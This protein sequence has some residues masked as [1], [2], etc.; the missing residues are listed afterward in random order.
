M[1]IALRGAVSGMSLVLMVSIWTSRIMRDAQFAFTFLIAAIFLRTWSTLPESIW[2][3]D[4]VLQAFQ[5]FGSIGAFAVTWFLLVIFLDHRRFIWLWLAS[6]ALISIWIVL[7][8]LYPQTVPVLRAYASAHFLGLLVVILYS[9]LDDLQDARRRIRP[10]MSSFLLVYCI[11]LSLTSQPMQD[12]RP[13][14]DALFQSSAL[15]FFMG[16]FAIW[17]LK[18]N[19]SNWPGATTSRPASTP[20]AQDSLS[21]QTILI[22]RIQKAMDE[23]IWQTEGL[24]VGGL[25]QHVKAPEHQVRKAINQVLGH[26]NF[27]NFINRARID[28][29]KARLSDLEMTENTILEIAYYVGFSSLGP[30]NRAFRENTGLSP[31]DFRKQILQE[32]SI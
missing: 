3:P 4:R 29:A 19:L 24:T 30:F 5:M 17:A 15:F 26:R 20:G 14:R 13:I 18:A 16:L 27:A 1:D 6:G 2:M 12:T 10:A 9:G 22:R 8:Q 28:A 11:G 32:A 23:G 31:T 25:A 7:S 21:E